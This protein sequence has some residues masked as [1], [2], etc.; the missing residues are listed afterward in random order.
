MRDFAHFAGGP[1]AGGPRRTDDARPGGA[2]NVA[3]NIAAL[4]A[5]ALLVGV[6]GR[7]EAADSLAN[8]PQGRWSG[9]ALPAHR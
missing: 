9:R 8:S 5:Q 6:T 4:G 1:G 2:A 3:L 7:D